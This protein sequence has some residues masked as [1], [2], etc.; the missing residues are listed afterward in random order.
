VLILLLTAAE[1]N[2]RS[3]R[4]RSRTA[5]RSLR[6]STGSRCRIQATNGDFYGTTYR[7]EPTIDLCKT[8]GCGEVFSLSAGL[9]PFLKMLPTSARVGSAVKILG[10][11]LPGVT[12]VSF[13]G[14]AAAFTVVSPALISTEGGGAIARLHVQGSTHRGR[15]K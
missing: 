15:L 2:P 7:A 12:S 14:N 4:S 6:A 5:C 11:N 3:C 8:S 13:H 9:N 10:T 1:I